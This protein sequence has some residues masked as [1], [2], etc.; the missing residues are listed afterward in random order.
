M[1]NCTPLF[2]FFMLLV[3]A[4][5]SIAQMPVDIGLKGG[6]SIPDISYGGI[7]APINGAHTYRSGA[8]AATDIAIHVS[9]HFSLQP[10]LEYSFQGNINLG[11]QAIAGPALTGQPFYL[12]NFSPSSLLY[13][14]FSSSTE[15][16]Y[17]VFP[18][19]AKYTFDI[20]H[21][22][23]AFVA[24][25]PSFNT[26]LS[27]KY[28]TS[29]NSHLYFDNAETELFTTTPQS[30]NKTEN[31]KNDVQAVHTAFAEYIGMQYK[32]KNHGRLI[33]EAGQKYGTIN[34]HKDGINANSRTGAAE[35]L[36]GYQFRVF[37]GKTKKANQFIH[38]SE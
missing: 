6:L 35:L 26:V 32:L 10:E 30:F 14:N 7:V 31:I 22:W 18:V 23:E 5:I 38:L 28:I 17:L 12:N 11:V 34:I 3:L 29:G 33:V 36:L 37:T 21:R 13:A 9:K 20:G 15:V 1:K 27:A 25:G 2:V 19:L 8:A 4:N 24:A 16:S